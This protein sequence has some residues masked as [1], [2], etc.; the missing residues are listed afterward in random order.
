MW[1]AFGLLLLLTA[2]QAFGWKDLSPAPP[3]IQAQIDALV[4]V[5]SEAQSPLEGPENPLR[6][7]VL[8]RLTW[9]DVGRKWMAPTA[10]STHLFWCL[11]AWCFGWGCQGHP[12]DLLLV[13]RVH[14][15]EFSLEV[16]VDSRNG[17]CH[18]LSAWNA[19]NKEL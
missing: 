6:G 12:V 7:Q 13:D 14:P 10:R 8:D 19:L 2:A 11:S 3:D 17:A 1:K 4:V 18:V 15:V 9:G 5:V 16:D